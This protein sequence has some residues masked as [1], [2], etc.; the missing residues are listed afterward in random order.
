MSGIRYRAWLLVLVVAT[1]P[2]LAGPTI[3][4]V[5]RVIAERSVPNWRKAAQDM[6]GLR[7]NPPDAAFA[8]KWA[9]V[10]NETDPQT[11]K[12]PLTRVTNPADGTELWQYATWLRW[13]ILTQNADGRYSYAYALNLSQMR[14]RD[15]DFLKEAA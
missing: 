1:G 12:A 9:S 13:R 15:G 8:A 14:N 5:Q 4:Q 11:G 6:S 2:S 7:G 3:E 10:D